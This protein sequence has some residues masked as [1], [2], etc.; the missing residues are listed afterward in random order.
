MW[1]EELKTGKLRAVERY[2]DPLTEK[3]K[4]VS[5]TIPDRKRK[6]LK[7]AE[8]ALEQKIKNALEVKSDRLKLEELAELYLADCKKRLKPSTI[9]RKTI[10]IDK[11]SEEIGT[12]AYIDKLTAKC[13]SN[14]SLSAGCVKEIKS[15]LKWAYIND[16]IDDI[17]F[18]AKIKTP[19]RTHREGKKYME[20]EELTSLLSRI[21]RDDYRDLTEFLAL[22]G[23]RVGEALA[24]T[25][26]DIDLSERLISV[27]KTFYGKTMV[28]NDSPKTESSRREIYIQD[29]LLTL[30][31]RLYRSTREKS[32]FTQC[33]YIFQNNGKA[34]NYNTYSKVLRRHGIHPHMLRHTHTALLAEQG[35]PLDVISRRLGHEN[36]KITREIYYHVTEKQREKDHEAVRRVSIF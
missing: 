35:V 8:K 17:N 1:I 7:E 29:D 11:L 16:Y 14:C 24:I 25:I 28:L 6:T 18:L 13:I 31:K 21:Q 12:D 4:K 9:H 10:V 27:N 36:S 22:T 30:V 26:D 5:I 32:M 20:P 2:T 33:K 23:M 3:Q 34:I 19:E 15:M